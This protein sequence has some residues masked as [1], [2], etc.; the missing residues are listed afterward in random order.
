MTNPPRQTLS[1]LQRRLTETGLRLAG[2]LGQNFLV[3]LNLLHLLVDAADLGPDDVVLEVGTGT[4]SL[5]AL[6]AAR[7]AAL[8]TVEIDTRLQQLAEEELSEFANITLLKQDALASKHQI[9]PRVM[10]AVNEALSA[11]PGR[12]FKLVANLP[13][14]IATP[15][16]ANLLAGDVVPSSMTVTIQKELADR[17]MAAPSTGDYGA[18]SILVQSQCRV[19]LVRLLPPTAFWPRP[20]VHSAIV[21]I[22]VDEAA[23]GRIADRAFSAAFV[24]AIFLHRR[25]LLR[26]A[27]VSACRTLSKADADRLLS[28]CGLP[29][30]A[31]AEALDPAAMLRLAETVRAAGGTV[32]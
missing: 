31:R 14:C 11:A 26:S 5:A 6:I 8:V 24:R 17:L 2:R 25:K 13:Y 28:E 9:D 4:G 7:A 30:D 27:L 32:A 29:P 21:H 16:I 15:V 20:K 10:A 3:D 18:L 12:R 23:R 1:Y 22:V 19:E